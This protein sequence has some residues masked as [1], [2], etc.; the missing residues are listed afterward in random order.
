MAI[1]HPPTLFFS[2]G[3]VT[4]STGTPVCGE[5]V[6]FKTCTFADT[7]TTQWQDPRTIEQYYQLPS[8]NSPTLRPTYT[9]TQGD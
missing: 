2:L 3:S 4:F 8:L 7:K 1:I 6:G 5:Y 9:E